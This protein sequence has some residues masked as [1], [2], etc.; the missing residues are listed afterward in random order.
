M[1]NKYNFPILCG[2]CVLKHVIISFSI[3]STV[4][5]KTIFKRYVFVFILK[6]ILAQQS[7]ILHQYLIHPLRL[8]PGPFINK[9]KINNH[10]RP[11]TFIV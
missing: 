11:L 3:K 9:K 5:I 1:N 8:E 4:R 2:Q 7:I 6:K 10:T